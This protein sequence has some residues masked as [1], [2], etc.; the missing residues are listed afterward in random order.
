MSE[1]IHG[2]VA[3]RQSRG[4]YEASGLK[5]DSAHLDQLAQH[6]AAIYPSES[7]L[8]IQEKVA[9]LGGE[10]EAVAA[11]FGETLVQVALEACQDHRLKHQSLL[12]LLGDI[13]TEVDQNIFALDWHQRPQ[14]G[15]LILNDGKLVSFTNE[16]NSPDHDQYL[17]WLKTETAVGA[18]RWEEEYSIKLIDLRGQASKR[19]SVYTT[20]SIDQYSRRDFIADSQ[21]NEYLSQ[22]TRIQQEDRSG[23]DPD[24]YHWSTYW[25]PEDNDLLASWKEWQSTF[26]ESV[27]GY[28]LEE[29]VKE[30]CVKYLKSS[31]DGDEQLHQVQLAHNTPAALKEAKALFH[32]SHRS[33]RLPSE[34][35]PDSSIKLWQLGPPHDN[36]HIE[37]WQKRQQDREDALSLLND[38]GKRTHINV[39]SRGQADIYAQNLSSSL[40][41]LIVEN[42]RH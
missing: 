24:H 16:S 17:L 12:N 40:S 14:E 8:A 18:H 6:L 35:R 19:L 37:L 39:D 42:I 38:L 13:R 32:E 21:N 15:A 34:V 9:A 7:T 31:I 28:I 1:L 3:S 41:R 5:I 20:L 26:G 36:L 11:L 30:A 22:L 27:H 4:P 10:N 29:I 33:G 25:L 2:V 23:Y